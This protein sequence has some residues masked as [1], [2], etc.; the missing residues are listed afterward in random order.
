MSL[1]RIQE[2]LACVAFN[3]ELTQQKTGIDLANSTRPSRT[4]LR[5]RGPYRGQTT[6]WPL[7]P[8]RRFKS[9]TD[10]RK[11]SSYVGEFEVAM[12]AIWGS[13]RGITRSFQPR[14]KKQARPNF[15]HTDRT[16]FRRVSFLGPRPRSSPSSE[17]LIACSMLHYCIRLVA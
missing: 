3:N 13:C 17:P 12:T 15:S 11:N 1:D 14:R 9:A 2:K 8:E 5:G 16:K 4:E 6:R 7:A 10:E